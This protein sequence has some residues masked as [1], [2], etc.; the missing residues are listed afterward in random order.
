VNDIEHAERQ[1][2][3]AEPPRF[4]RHDHEAVILH[5]PDQAADVLDTRLNQR[6]QIPEVAGWTTDQR[7]V[8][9]WLDEFGGDEVFLRACVLTLNDGATLS[10]PKVVTPSA[11]VAW[12]VTA[13]LP[14]DRL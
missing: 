9:L 14:K 5:G 11:D 6:G 1:H 8:F 4:R 13:T 7:P 2:R 3:P 10:L 12:P